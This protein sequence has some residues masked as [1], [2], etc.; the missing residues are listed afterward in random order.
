MQFRDRVHGEVEIPD[1]EILAL[2]SC[3]TMQR[4]GRIKQAGPSALAL[5]GKDV[6]RLE[7]SLGVFL[8]L[9]RLGADRKEQVA[10]LLH[11]ISHTAFSHVVDFVFASEEHDFHEHLKPASLDRPDVV[12]ALATTGFVPADFH[13][14]SAYA[15]LERP[16]PWLCADRVDYFLRDGLAFGVLTSEMATRIVEDLAVVDRTIVFTDVE[17]ARAA[18]ER[19]AI[20]NRES[21]AS[22]SDGFVYNEFAA[23]LRAA[24]AQGVLTRDDLLDDD[25]SVMKKLDA[26]SHPA[27]RAPLDRVLH[28]HVGMLDG[29]VEAIHPKE[30]RL[31]PPVRHGDSFRRLSELG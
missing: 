16:L 21:W 24:L 18:A 7:H 5:A 12:T 29:Y 3:P 9:R 13:D 10:G 1:P 30:R 6:T 2:V 19:F 27:I 28:F 31:D 22:P 23:A 14:D 17:V 15:L 8:L 11:D 4:L 26:C 25:A 20:M